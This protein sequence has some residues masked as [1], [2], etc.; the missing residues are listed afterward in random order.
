MQLTH[1]ILVSGVLP[2]TKRNITPDWISDHED[3][4]QA[5]LRD[6][7]DLGRKPT[8]LCKKGPGRGL[9][10][11]RL[12]SGRFILRRLPE[13]GA[14]HDPECA[15]WDPD[16]RTSGM[17]C[18]DVPAIRGSAE[19]G[20]SLRLSEAIQPRKESEETAKVPS[21]A[22]PSPSTPKRQP[23]V[24]ML[25]LLH[26]LWERAR[27]NQWRPG[28][29]GKRTGTAFG[30]YIAETAQE[31]TVSRHKLNSILVHLVGGDARKVHP[32]RLANQQAIGNA[33]AKGSRVMLLGELDPS[34]LNAGSWGAFLHQG[35]YRTFVS[36]PK[37]VQAAILERIGEHYSAILALETGEPRIIVLGL[38]TPS[39]I[40]VGH[41]LTLGAFAVML[42]T[43]NYIPVESSHEWRVARKLEGEGRRFLKP[44]RYDAKEEVFP[45]F[46]LLDAEK[47]EVP[48][49]VY[50][51]SSEPYLARKAEKEAYYLS[52]YGLKGWWT[53]DA[54]ST[55]TIP[56]F[57]DRLVT[58]TETRGG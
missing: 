20:F 54:T 37:Q 24:S 40:T 2:G 44:L 27:F 22:S 10:P 58:H 42:T 9:G 57:P 23:A 32:F 25:G 16:P 45:D 14:E 36:I 21:Q 26:F 47:P 41:R 33:L 13:T 30:G 15:F 31:V 4:W 7:H 39:R 55:A 18:Y 50:G 38:A 56:T 12:S 51:L 29:A 1:P 35:L 34:S 49:E 48:M 52:Q 8:C 11:V 3:A 28:M 5:I 19:S 53:W 46:I 6:H 17:Q 43:P